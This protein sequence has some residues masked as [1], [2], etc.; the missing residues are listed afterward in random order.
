MVTLR[1][2]DAQDA[3]LISRMIAASW[4]SAYRGLIDS[5]YL[6]RLPDGYWTP[7]MRAWLDS[8]RMNGLIAETDGQPAGCI[9]FGRSREEERPD[10]GEIVSLYLLP[11]AMGKGLGRLLLTSAVQSLREDG[12]HHIFLW[13]IQGAAQAER[14]YLRQGFRPAADQVQYRIGSQLVTDVRYV[15]TA[16]PG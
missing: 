1:N 4:R 9:I 7:S 12:Y 8:G 11:E 14:F 5:T 3:P 13:A 6:D 10:W 15:L 2:A 16:P